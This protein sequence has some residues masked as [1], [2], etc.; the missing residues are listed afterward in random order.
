MWE[1]GVVDGR[2]W[3]GGL[4]AA[5]WASQVAMVVKGRS[6]ASAFHDFSL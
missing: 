3:L 1:A 5:P 6:D 2:G 4:A